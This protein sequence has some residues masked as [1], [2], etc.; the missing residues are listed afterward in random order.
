MQ[1]LHLM[2]PIELNGQ[3]MFS[4]MWIDPDED[5][6]ASTDPK[7]RTAKLLIKFDIKD[8]GLFD[9]LMVYEKE[10]VSMRLFYPDHL[11]SFESD[12]KKGMGEI[13][14]R[15]GLNC[16][17]LGVEQA[18]GSIPVSSVFPKIFE[19]KNAVNVTI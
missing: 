4:E 17:Y 7:E 2:L 15:N 8:V 1:V 16:E 13:L 10:N 9:L 19:R 11:S 5:G 18:K 14:D 12:I 6:T 3:L